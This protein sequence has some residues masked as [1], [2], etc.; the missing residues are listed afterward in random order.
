MAELALK[1]A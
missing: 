1:C